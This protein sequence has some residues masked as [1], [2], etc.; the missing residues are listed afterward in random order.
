MGGTNTNVDG[1]TCN[2]NNVEYAILIIII[3]LAC[4]VFFYF[5]YS[6]NYYANSSSNE[7]FDYDDY[8]DNAIFLGITQDPEYYYGLANNFYSYYGYWPTWWMSYPDFYY[9]RFRRYPNW[10]GRYGNLW[11]RRRYGY[12]NRY[13]RRSAFG[14][15]NLSRGFSN[16]SIRSGNVHGISSRSG[17]RSGRSGGR[18]G[19]R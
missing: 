17:G 8:S 9:T 5:F 7:G 19:R 16:R 18:G 12:G 2:P 4:C 10:W 3:L 1:V 14:R 6:C 13:A 15:D 11:N